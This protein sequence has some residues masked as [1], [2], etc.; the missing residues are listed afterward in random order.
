ML[1]VVVKDKDLVTKDDFVGKIGF[2]I[3]DVPIRLPSDGPLAPQW[4]RL[5]DRR[6]IKVRG[7]LMLAV[8]MGT[9]ADEAFL[10]AWHSDAH[11][12]SHHNLAN[13]R[14][15]V[16]FSPKFYYLRIHVIEAQ[17]LIPEKGV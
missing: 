8:W 6:G 13:T 17:D 3:V 12:I 16:Y 7:E 10:G 14:S 9:Q 11:G 5:E 2:D 1:E 15:N 4:Y